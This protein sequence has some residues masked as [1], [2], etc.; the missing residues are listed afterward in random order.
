MTVYASG[1]VNRSI[2]YR[3]LRGFSGKFNQL[4]HLISFRG[5]VTMCCMYMT[6]YIVQFYIISFVQSS[7]VQDSQHLFNTTKLLSKFSLLLPALFLHGIDPLPIFPVS[8]T[9][10]F[11]LGLGTDSLPAETGAASRFGVEERKTPFG[12]RFLSLVVC[13]DSICCREGVGHGRSDDAVRATLHPPGTV[14]AWNVRD[15]GANSC[16]Y[17][18]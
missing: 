2:R 16:F 8:R 1:L 18:F 3:N 17:L 7:L 11:L 12:V 10:T 4:G 15:D 13:S 9:E 14:E 5:D 6:T